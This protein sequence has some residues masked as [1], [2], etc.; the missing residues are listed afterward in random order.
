MFIKV[1]VPIYV[2]IAKNPKRGKKYY[3][4]FNNFHNWSPIQRSIIKNRYSEIIKAQLTNNST[5][6]T[7]NVKCSITYYPPDRRRH[8]LDNHTMLHAK[9]CNDALTEVGCWADD[10]CI[11]EITLKR[12]PLD[13]ANPRVELHYEI[14]AVAETI[15]KL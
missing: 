13:K 4:S 11:S 15:N 6:F 2:A 9:F 8:D 10:D 5:R 1:T 7:V 12:G 3:L 14:H